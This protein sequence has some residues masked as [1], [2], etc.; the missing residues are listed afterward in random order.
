MYNLIFLQ[1]QTCEKCLGTMHSAIHH[2]ASEWCG[3]S[4][5]SALTRYAYSFARGR[6]LQ[7]VSSRVAIASTRVMECPRFGRVCHGVITCA[8][9]SAEL[10]KYS[11]RWI[12]LTVRSWF[13]QCL[14]IWES[15]PKS[16]P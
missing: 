12:S 16:W 1:E 11:P 6:L 2:Q 10:M 13:S 9:P 8:S 14:G 4:V 15:P 3:A 7:R 5:H